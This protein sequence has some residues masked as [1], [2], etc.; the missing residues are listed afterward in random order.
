MSVGVLFTAL[1]LRMP[2]RYQV[3]TTV[4]HS[5][6]IMCVFTR[7]QEVYYLSKMDGS[8][9]VQLL[10]LG[11]RFGWAITLWSMGRR[12]PLLWSGPVM[13]WLR[14]TLTAGITSICCN[15]RPVLYDH[16]MCR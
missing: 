14:K 8:H 7:H 16:W 5:I 2:G 10:L 12:A 4:N 13:V 11:P 15:G 6:E 1:P 3:R 9:L